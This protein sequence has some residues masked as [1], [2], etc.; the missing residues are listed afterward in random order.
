MMKWPDKLAGYI[1]TIGRWIKLLYFWAIPSKGRDGWG[2]RIAVFQDRYKRIY[3]CQL[4]CWLH[5]FM[6]I[7]TVTILFGWW[8]IPML[9][10]PGFYWE[11]QDET[12]ATIKERVWILSTPWRWYAPDAVPTEQDI[13]LTRRVPN[14]NNAD[15]VRLSKDWTSASK[16]WS[17]Y[18]FW[19]ILVYG[20]IPRVIFSGLSRWSLSSAI[21]QLPLDTQRFKALLSRMRTPLVPPPPPPPPPPPRH[22]PVP[23]SESHSIDSCLVLSALGMEPERLKSG[24]ISTGVGQVSDVLE[25]GDLEMNGDEQALAA[26]DEFSTDDEIVIVVLGSTLPLGEDLFLVREIRKK[27]GNSRLIHVLPCEVDAD[28]NLQPADNDAAGIWGRKLGRLLPDEYLALC[29]LSPGTVL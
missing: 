13:A 2:T 5:R 26:L 6:L 29:I 11:S 3:T 18:L 20:L 12:P 4:I 1:S 24:L 14:D 27:V 28:G 21:R 7:Y 10:H 19:S 17:D 22:V 25:I 16:A 23:I 8:T 15:R 9:K